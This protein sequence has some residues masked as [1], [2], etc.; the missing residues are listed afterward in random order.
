M[1]FLTKQIKSMKKIRMNEGKYAFLPI[2][3]VL[4]MAKFT[5][6]FIFIGLLQVSASIY[7]QNVKLNLKMQNVTILEVFEQIEKQCDYRFF[8][9]NDLK[10]LTKRI[11]VESLDK[12]L[13]DIL[14]E[15][16]SGTNIIYRMKD[17]LILVQ[18]KRDSYSEVTQQKSVSGKVTDASGGPLPG[19]SVVIKGTTKGIITDVDGK[20]SLANIPANA[21]LQFSFV[22]MKTQEISTS[23]KN[24]IDIKMEQESVGL[25]EVVAVG[26]GKQSRE[27]LTTSISKMNAAV[28]KN[29]PYSNVASSLQGA[30]AG[31]R[32]QT[33]SGMPG[34]TPRVI[35]R[36]GT[37]INSPDSATP[38]YIVD[39]IIR[40]DLVSIDQSDIESIQVLKDAASTSIYGARASNGVVIIIT[41]SGQLGKVRI[42]YKYNMTVSDNIKYYD[43][44][45][46]RD[47]ITYQ[48]LG[49]YRTGTRA[50]KSSVLT[51]LTGANSAGTGNDL[52]NSTG[53]TTQYLASANEYKLNEGWQSMPDPLDEGKTLIFDDFDF[54]RNTYRTGISNTHSLSASGGNDRATFNVGL[55][56]YNADGVVI[57]TQYERFNAHLNGTLKIN[58][59]LSVFGRTTYAKSTSNDPT[60]ANTFGRS[61]GLPPTAK[62]KFEDGTLAPGANSSLG[63]NE[64]YLNTVNNS[65]AVDDLSFVIGFSW[66]I[67]PEL[68]FDPQISLY[69][70]TS[71]ARTFQEAY[72]NGAASYV[73]TRNATASY[74]NYMQKQADVV[75]TY[76]KPFGDGHNLEAKAGFSYYKTK[77]TAF[78]ANGTGAAT[79]LIPTLSASATPSAVSGS[80][81]EQLIYGF[82]GRINYDYKQK[83]LL[84]VNTRYD[85]ASNLGANYKWGLFPGVSVG[86]NLHKE[87]FWAN[88]FSADMKMKLRGSYGINGNISGLGAYT[89]QG[90]Y[91]S[92]TQYGGNATIQNTVMANSELQWE[93][94][95]TFDIG[96]DLGLFNNRINLVVDVYRRET[97]NLLASLSLPY[98][99]GFSSTTTN[100]GS[101]QNKGLE[102]ELSAKILNPVNVLQWD[103]SFNIAFVKSKILKLPY[104]GV[105]KNRVGG[106]YV[107]D[108]DTKTYSYKGGLQEGG[109][110][111][112]Y[113][114]YKMLGVYATDEAAASAP[115]DA[116]CTLTD[117]KCYGGDVILDDLDG[118]GKI[119]TVDQTYGGSI[120]PKVN[121]GFS[122]TFTYKNLSLLVRADF[123]LGHTIFNYIRGTMIGQF[124]GDN[125][126]STDLLRSWKNQGDVTDIPKFYYAD[127]MVANKLYRGGVC[128]SMF[129]EKGNYL[130][131]REVT[132]SYSLPKSLLQKVKLDVV[133]VNLT[134]NNLYYF[135]KYKGLNPEYGGSDTGR[136]PLPR[137]ITLGIDITF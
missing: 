54:Q 62:Y 119:T 41:K 52:T 135:T 53:F 75:F 124:Q 23:G 112:D 78:A 39:G 111:G 114:V 79:D 43:L 9:D 57:T 136:Y 115:V 91:A 50:Q 107:Y 81:S 21:I 8:Y 60:N 96:T 65:N 58:D 90:T 2:K 89:A 4:I 133:S 121:G 56:Y 105:D 100:M 28:L 24:T 64:Y 37:S 42:N 122:N 109:E 97:K 12:P 6:F 82:F 71:Y 104:N 27:V 47:H 120:Y 108:R 103:F 116:L 73:S 51:L 10:D 3:K 84:T 110:I 32:V 72:W 35:V 77:A 83:Y 17:R 40:T 74:S 26:Y 25:E 94:S 49:L 20:Y 14:N 131:L 101:L 33:T 5:T 102:I 18:S 76:V 130:A 93:Q 127:Q 87:D 67:L 106:T 123:T 55:G 95:H 68:T 129:Y 132:L 22:G 80:E 125:G 30:L 16:F 117:K 66:K 69:Q 44:L 45:G 85:G 126:L 38:L 128:N 61:S 63:N 98:S 11:T 1:S 86:W 48:R 88:T 92:G 7:S 113:Y 13:T 99:T 118:D 137:N 31:V 34:A 15:I 36:G 29:I 70:R 134:G 46:A 19:V 59:K